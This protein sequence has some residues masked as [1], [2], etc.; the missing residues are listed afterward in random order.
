ME[1]PYVANLNEFILHKKHPELIRIA[2]ALHEKKVAT[3]CG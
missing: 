2:E 1:L 3:D